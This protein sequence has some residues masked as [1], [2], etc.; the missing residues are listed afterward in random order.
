[1]P[2]LEYALE[3]AGMAQA[4]VGRVDVPPTA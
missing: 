3:F 4:G 2:A 1:M